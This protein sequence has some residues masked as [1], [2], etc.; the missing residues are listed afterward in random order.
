MPVPK[1]VPGTFFVSVNSFERFVGGFTNVL[2]VGL[3]TPIAVPSAIPPIAYPGA[4]IIYGQF[5]K[6]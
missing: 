4:G 1:K 6:N 5:H 2:N 3:A